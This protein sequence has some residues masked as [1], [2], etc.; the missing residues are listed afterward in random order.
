MAGEKFPRGYA[1]KLERYRYGPGVFKMDWALNAPV[2]WR[3]DACTRAG[4]VHLGGSME[5]IA[6]SERD[7]EIGVKHA[8]AITRRTSALGVGAEQRGLHI[9]GLRERLA[10]GLQHIGVSRG[11]AASRTTN[12]QDVV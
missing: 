4:T 9:V 3:A 12:G 11:V 2:P 10:N 1:Q 6:R 5:E 8:R 7:R